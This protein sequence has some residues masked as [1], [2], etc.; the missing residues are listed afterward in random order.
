[1]STWRRD[2]RL[3]ELTWPNPENVLVV[4]RVGQPVRTRSDLDNY[5]YTNEQTGEKEDGD[6][7]SLRMAAHREQ[8][9]LTEAA[10]TNGSSCRLEGVPTHRD[11][12]HVLLVDVTPAEQVTY[13]PDHPMFAGGELGQCNPGA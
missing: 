3:R 8:F 4:V 1:M 6:N 13:A 11:E 9:A 5:P 7:R 10:R 2:V 12:P